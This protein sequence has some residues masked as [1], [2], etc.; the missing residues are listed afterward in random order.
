MWEPGTL[1]VRSSAVFSSCKNALLKNSSW[2]SV[3]QYIP[4]VEFSCVLFTWVS[5]SWSS[6][7][8]FLIRK[9]E[10]LRNFCLHF[11]CCSY[12]V[13]SSQKMILTA[14]THAL[15]RHACTSSRDT[16]S[17]G[18]WYTIT[19]HQFVVMYILPWFIPVCILYTVHYWLVIYWL[20]TQWPFKIFLS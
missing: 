19:Y 2:L 11:C 20:Q 14:E 10:H 18:Q 7:Y 17:I 8:G 4:V 9:L 3:S 12:V 6:L 16:T 5:I 15:A 13:L 1:L